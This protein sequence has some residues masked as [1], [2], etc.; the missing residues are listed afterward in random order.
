MLVYR[1]GIKKFENSGLFHCGAHAA[2]RMSDRL[3]RVGT[4][5]PAKCR[6]QNAARIEW[7]RAKTGKNHIEKNQG[8]GGDIEHLQSNVASK[9][10]ARE[11][12]ALVPF[13]TVRRTWHS[14]KKPGS[15]AIELSRDA[16]ENHK[17]KTRCFDHI[18]LRVKGMEVARKF[19]G[20]FLPELGFVHE[21][22]GDDFSTFYAG[23]ADRRMECFSI[24]EDKNHRPGLSAST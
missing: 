18:D 2:R 6:R 17:M 19:Y 3:P 7:N 20:K 23:G 13:R 11:E 15:H 22:P 10:Y 4:E 14:R 1:W 12:P 9:L 16:I 21:S 5:S 24:A 8:T